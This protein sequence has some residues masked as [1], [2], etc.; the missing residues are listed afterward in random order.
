M[1]IPDTTQ[2]EDISENDL[3]LNAKSDTETHRVMYVYLP[4]TLSFSNSIT[5]CSASNEDSDVELVEYVEHYYLISLYITHRL[6]QI[7]C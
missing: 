4:Y 6:L 3:T 7:S 2:T 5:F 1:E